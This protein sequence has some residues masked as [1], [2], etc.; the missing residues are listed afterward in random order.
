MFEYLKRVIITH[1]QYRKYIFSRHLWSLGDLERKHQNVKIP[2]NTE[3]AESINNFWK[4]Y[5][6]G[7]YAKKSFDLKWFDIYNSLNVNHNRLELYIPDDFY[8]CFVDA[9]YSDPRKAKVLDDKN[10]Y[11]M[12]FNDIKQPKTIARRING[13][14]MSNSY[15]L[16]NEKELLDLCVSAG[17]VIVKKSVNSV[18]GKGIYFWDTNSKIEDLRSH[19]SDIS[20]FVVQEIIEQHP[21]LSKLNESSINTIRIMTFAYNGKIN[22]L[23]SLI[24][25]GVSGMRVD[26][27]SSGGLACG[28]DN[29][30]GKLKNFA[31]DIKANICYE[32]PTGVKFSDIV[33]PNFDKCIELVKKLAPRFINVS[34]L[35]SWDLSVGTDGEPILIEA[36]LTHGGLSIHQM[37]NGPIFGNMTE[38]VLKNVLDNNVLLS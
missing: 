23:S 14:N 34:K 30:T 8:H 26:N 24:R 16:I 13:L 10:M 36:N 17:N 3:Q 29:T 28:I 11:D 7:R 1:F 4:K 35:I 22:I 32:H 21:E 25:M 5:I 20:D 19:I 27:A 18:G 6:K 33:I 9:H 37:T 12:Y 38:E 31:V 2:I 15:E